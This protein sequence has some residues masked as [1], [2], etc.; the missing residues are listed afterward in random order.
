MLGRPVHGPRDEL[1]GAIEPVGTG[2]VVL[3]NANEH[4]QRSHT[5]A[6]GAAAADAG[7]ELGADFETYA[8]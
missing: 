2:R 3:V 6:L 5:G 4:L 8:V 1:V 7:Y